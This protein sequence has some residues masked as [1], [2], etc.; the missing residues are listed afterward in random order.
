MNKLFS[1]IWIGFLIVIGVYCIFEINK[2]IA[3]DKVNAN[4]TSITGSIFIFLLECFIVGWASKE[5]TNVLNGD[6]K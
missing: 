6:K 3:I 4:V 2:V 5:M 1:T